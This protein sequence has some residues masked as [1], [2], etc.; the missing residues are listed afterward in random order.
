MTTSETAI[1]KELAVHGANAVLGERP[2]GPQPSVAT[3]G[4]IGR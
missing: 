2:I 1:V 3:G 4:M